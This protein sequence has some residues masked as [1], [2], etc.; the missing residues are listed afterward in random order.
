MPSEEATRLTTLL[1]P[2]LGDWLF[3]PAAYCAA[4]HENTDYECGPLAQ[5][6]EPCPQCVD[7]EFERQW[8]WE[9]DASEEQTH[10]RLERRRALERHPDPAWVIG[11]GAPK[12]LDDPDLFWAAFGRY[13][14]TDPP[15]SFNLGANRRRAEV[16]WRDIVWQGQ[17]RE[18]MAALRGAWTDALAFLAEQGGDTDGD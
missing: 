14:A 15:L 16:W 2:T 3:W 7:D 13:L 5:V 8:P 10:A 18:A 1:T 4:G 6:G 12:D 11:R 17:Q 9:A